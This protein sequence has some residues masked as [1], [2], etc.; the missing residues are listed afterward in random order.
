MTN[1]T[2]AGGGGRTA[3][4]LGVSIAGI[5]GASALICRALVVVP[6]HKRH[7]LGKLVLL[8]L[9]QHLLHVASAHDCAC[10]CAR[11]HCA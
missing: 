2:G 4:H 11:V 9:V 10:A 5:Q 6:S 7:I 1:K 8:M 3:N